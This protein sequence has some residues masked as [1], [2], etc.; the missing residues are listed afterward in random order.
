MP[1][2][3]KLFEPDLTA[4]VVVD[5]WKGS[6]P[7]QKPD[8]PVFF[9]ARLFLRSDIPRTTDLER[10][11]RAANAGDWHGSGPTSLFYG[12][13]ASARIISRLRRSRSRFYTRRT[14]YGDHADPEFQE[15]INEVRRDHPECSKA[16]NDFST[17]YTAGL[18]AFLNH[19]ASLLAAQQEMHVVSDVKRLRIVCDVQDWQQGAR[20]TGGLIPMPIQQA[21]DDIARG[22]RAESFTI[23]RDDHADVDRYR[24]FMGLV[25]SEAYAYGRVLTT[26]LRDGAT[27]QD[28]IA[29]RQP[30]EPVLSDEDL[31]HV[32]ETRLHGKMAAYIDSVL[33]THRWHTVWDP[34]DPN[35]PG[36]PMMM[37]R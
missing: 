17:P 23:R 13:D 25:D 28:R 6:P 31:V 30:D 9:A 15:Q 34:L 7:R 8:D 33:R 10:L 21:K 11:L 14:L 36:D 27:I 5:D 16:W 24:P 35:R 4:V 1:K 12:T 19:L 32:A 18:F 2:P 20:G 37:I 3:I 22:Y 29:A 26:K